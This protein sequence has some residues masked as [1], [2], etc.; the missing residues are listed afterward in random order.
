MS[1]LLKSVGIENHEKAAEAR[2]R[3]SVQVALQNAMHRNC[4]TQR[5]L[6]E[7]LGV[8]PARVSQMLSSPSA[9][10]T[11]KSVARIAD[12]VG[13]EFDLVPIA[14]SVERAKRE[15]DGARCSQVVDADLFMRARAT[16]RVHWNEVANNEKLRAPNDRMAVAV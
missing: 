9:N 13:E 16:R 10:L 4:I 11:I 8:T 12:A 15:R 2:L 6:A 5:E 14:Q 1:K 3:L 7:K